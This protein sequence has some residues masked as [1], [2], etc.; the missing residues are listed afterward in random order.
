MSKATET[1][2]VSYVNTLVA[3]CPNLAPYIEDGDRTPLTDGFIDIYSSNKK[4]NATTVGRVDVQ[5]KG[6][7]LK[8]G[9]VTPKNYRISVV[10]LRAHLNL[11][12]VL[13]LVVNL[14]ENSANAEAW[15][16]ILNPF[17]IER[18]LSRIKP[19]QKT[20]AV[21]LK[22]FPEEAE[23]I[24]EIVKLAESMKS[25]DPTQTVDPEVLERITEFD[26]RGIGVLDLEKPV[27]LN[28]EKDDFMI[29]AK[30]EGG[31]R[32]PLSG[33]FEILPGEY[34][35]EPFEATVS[36]GGVDFTNPVRCRVDEETVEFFLGENLRWVVA[37]RQ[38]SVVSSL[39]IHLSDVLSDRLRDLEF[40]VSC[41]ES[42]ELAINGNRVPMGTTDD[43]NAEELRQHL[44]YLRRLDALLKELGADTALIQLSDIGEMVS[45]RLGAIYRYLVEGAPLAVDR[46]D[47]GRVFQPLGDRGLELLVI[48][49]DGEQRLLDTFASPPQY[50]M[51][52]LGKN[53]GG[54]RVSWQVTPYEMLSAHDMVR[55]LNL[56]LDSIVDHYKAL[57][58]SAH[59]VSLA[60]ETVL[61]LVLAADHDDKRRRELLEGAKHLN[62]WIISMNGA[63]PLHQVNQLQITA[64]QRELTEEE[65]DSVRTLRRQAIRENGA[66]SLQMELGCALLLG[67]REDIADVVSQLPSEQMAEFR[68]WP[69]W[70][71]A[72]SKKVEM[73]APSEATVP[74]LRIRFMESRR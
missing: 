68:S 38:S 34:L 60:N 54:E 58:Q 37:S 72:G 35:G 27:F 53:P 22:R 43:A 7:T 62:E 31:L 15:F 21:D 30:T 5:V 8:K 73:P 49:H 69:L 10:D 11:S 67:V 50:V 23:R 45:I 2:A 12:C 16:V 18:I 64:R 1:R 65:R 70:N 52:E 6:R 32:I 13:F 48:E 46:R 9:K 42:G 17:R 33:D 63:L 66:N 61:R 25:Q 29:V 57:E 51:I 20:V 44:G 39:T 47:R 59:A 26:L 28:V 36:S 56:H 55:T 40:Y 19:D 71:L 4:T 14:E 41:I 3:L 24:E 74:D